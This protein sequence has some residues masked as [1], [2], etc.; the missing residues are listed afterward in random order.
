MSLFDDAIAKTKE[1]FC[2]V[3]QKTGEIVNVGKL[4]INLSSATSALSQNYEEL[5]KA[6]Y[7]V[8]QKSGEEPNEEIQGIVTEIGFRRSQIEE[9]KKQIAECK[10]SV[11]C[12]DCGAVNDDEALYCSKCGQR[13][14]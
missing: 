6:Q 3:E 12:K 5:G 2:A 9:L 7:E 8:M 11:I 4:K 10:G 13:L 1:A 14:K